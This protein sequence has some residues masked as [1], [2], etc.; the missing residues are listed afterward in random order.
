MESTAVAPQLAR[1]HSVD[2][3]ATYSEYANLGSIAGRSSSSNC[4]FLRW[5]SLMKV[6]TRFHVGGTWRCKDKAS[7]WRK[8]GNIPFGERKSQPI[9]GQCKVQFVRL[10]GAPCV[11]GAVARSQETT[12]ICRACRMGWF[13]VCVCVCVCGKG[14]RA[15]MRGD[16]RQCNNTDTLRASVYCLCKN[17]FGHS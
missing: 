12:P 13:R 1:N 15:W 7:T 14:L 16:L 11:G 8:T 17:R 5:F 3:N 4:D 10:V 9:V 2:A 6:Y